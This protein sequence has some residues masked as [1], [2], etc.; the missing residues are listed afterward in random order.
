MKLPSHP[1]QDAV[2]ED[3]GESPSGEIVPIGAYSKLSGF[4]E[5]KQNFK[6]E[7]VDVSVLIQ[8][9]KI[10]QATSNLEESHGKWRKNPRKAFPMDTKGV[11]GQRRRKKGTKENSPRL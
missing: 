6:N 7:W 4:F 5:S 8:S 11:P 9:F 3:S 2:A 10:L 1:T